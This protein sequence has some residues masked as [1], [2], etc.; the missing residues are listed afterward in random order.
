[1]GIEVPYFYSKCPTDQIVTLLLRDFCISQFP[2][3]SFHKVGSKRIVKIAIQHPGSQDALSGGKGRDFKI[4]QT[5]KNTKFLS[6]CLNAPT[7][8]QKEKWCLTVF[9]NTLFPFFPFSGKT[10]EAFLLNKVF[11]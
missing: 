8:L 7:I 10:W 4:S 1:M 3:W 5:E 6:L 9:L 2:F 11:C